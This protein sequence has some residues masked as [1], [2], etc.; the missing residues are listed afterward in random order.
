VA[1]ISACRVELR[2]AHSPLHIIC[3]P[4]KSTGDADGMRRSHL[5][6]RSLQESNANWKPWIH[7]AREALGSW[8]GLTPLAARHQSLVRPR[9]LN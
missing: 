9:R 6:R 7:P 5:E 3:R 2:S 4:S 1:A 8:I